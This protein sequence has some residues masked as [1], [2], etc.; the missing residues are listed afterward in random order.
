MVP[1]WV[2]PSVLH[3][4]LVTL[5]SFTDHLGEGLWSGSIRALH[6]GL[7]LASSLQR[8]QER[9]W[10][11]RQRLDSEKARPINHHR[12]L[13]SQRTPMHRL[14]SPWLLLSLYRREKTFQTCDSFESFSGWR[15]SEFI[16]QATHTPL[17]HFEGPISFYSHLTKNSISLWLWQQQI[18]YYI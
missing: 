10:T 2:G 4:S 8:C 7:I 15:P 5:A 14:W 12:A 17:E 13:F 16:A 9:S 18:R 3:P 6:T 1:I 11:F